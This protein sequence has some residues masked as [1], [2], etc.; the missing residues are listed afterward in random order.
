MSYEI[1]PSYASQGATDEKQTGVSFLKGMGNAT[2]L[3]AIA[4]GVVI[5]PKLLKS[6]PKKRKNPAKRRRRSTKKSR[7]L[8][9]K[10]GWRKRRRR[11]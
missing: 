10:R 6:K 4:L 9:A 7:S 5:V 1:L 3:I 2:A 11:R 8:A